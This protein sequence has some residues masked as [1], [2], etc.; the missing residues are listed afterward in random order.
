MYYTASLIANTALSARYQIN[1]VSN[2][3]FLYLKPRKYIISLS[4]SGT[5][6]KKRIMGFHTD[7]MN[8]DIQ[9]NSAS[10]LQEVDFAN[11][12]FGKHFTDHMFVADFDKGQWGDFRIVPFGNLE[13]HP[14]MAALH[15]GQSI[16]EGLKAYRSPEGD[17]LL[18][19]PMDNARRLNHSARRMCMAEL[20]EDYFMESLQRL[21][22]LDRNWVSGGEGHS[23]Y[24]RPFMFATEAFLGVKPS[25]QYRFMIFASPVG[26]YYQ[27]AIKVRVEPYYTR[28]AKGGT[29]TAKAAGN[30]AAALYPAKLGQDKGYRQLVWTDSDEHKYIEE[31]GTMNIFF[32]LDGKL[33]TPTL[34][35]GTILSGIT[36]DCVISIAKAWGIPVEERR[37]SVEEVIDG[38]SSKKLTEVFGAGTAATI[39]PID[40]MN[41]RETDYHLPPQESW[42]F[43]PKMLRYLTEIRTGR[44]EDPFGWTVRL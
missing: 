27:G 2:H 38:I 31:S 25:D 13:M 1:L 15:Y 26:N 18:F 24:I 36:R 7:T 17:V 6:I 20:P 21:I 9:K 11:L 23:L 22:D 39:A 3:I 41:I 19:R 28:A 5:K 30:Y 29:G 32:F 40:L 44:T 14:S 16:F 37:I 12:V 35:T 4:F 33:I 34:D 42:E 43:A 10:R 8:I